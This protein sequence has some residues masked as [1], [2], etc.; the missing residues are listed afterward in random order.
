MLSA[1]LT[2][3]L[4]WLLAG[5]LLGWLAHWWLCRCTVR[6]NERSDL[7]SDAASSSNTAQKSNLSA[8]AHLAGSMGAGL[9][10][11]AGAGAGA[12]GAVGAGLASGA[13]AVGAIGAAGAGLATGAGAAAAKLAAVSA[14]ADPVIDVAAAK[15]AGISVKGADDLEVIEGIGPKICGLFHAAG[16]KTFMQVSQ[17]SVQQMSTILDNAG[18]RFKLANPET[19]AQQ[20]KLAA[21]NQWPQLKALQDNLT[22]GVTMQQDRSE[23]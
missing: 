16:H 15:L 8:P 3:Y 5:A 20:A 18:P 13:G 7:R 6:S 4:W 17:M 11:I 19:W 2:C 22:A 14:P 1:F 21:H 9:K 12:V 10:G 23:L